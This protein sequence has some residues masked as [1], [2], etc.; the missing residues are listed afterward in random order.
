MSEQP[1]RGRP[2]DFVP[3]G[4]DPDRQSGRPDWVVT[5][6]PTVAPRADYNQAAREQQPSK[7]PVPLIELAAFDTVSDILVITTPDGG[8]RLKLNGEEIPLFI[9]EGYAPS[10][11]DAPAGDF[12]ILSVPFLVEADTVIEHI[13][14]LSE[15]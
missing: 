10:L 14:A 8:K 4:L 5:G 13:E 7:K 6:K 1:T 9:P 15:R 3:P 12:K 11:S 2:A